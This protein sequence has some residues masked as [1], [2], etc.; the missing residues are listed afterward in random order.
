MC[1]FTIRML[2][3]IVTFKETV[4]KMHEFTHTLIPQACFERHFHRIS[5]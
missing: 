1:T 2:K 4:T 3:A 5:F